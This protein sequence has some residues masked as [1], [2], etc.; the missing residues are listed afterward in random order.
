MFIAR[1][2]LQSVKPIVLPPAPS[3][4][5]GMVDVDFNPQAILGIKAGASREQMRRAY[6]SLAK[7]YHP[8]RYAAHFG[9][10]LGG[11]HASA[12]SEQTGPDPL[13][14]EA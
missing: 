12:E 2:A 11:P 8:D 5:V 13:P 4:S 9:V 14:D 1:S 6:L 10:P 3:L 7:T